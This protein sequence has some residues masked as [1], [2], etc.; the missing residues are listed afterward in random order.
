V[1]NELLITDGLR[2]NS[3]SGQVEERH[4]TY[5]WSMRS[6]PWTEDRMNLVTVTVTYEVQG[7]EYDVT[8]ATLYDSTQLSATQM[9]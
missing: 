4:R 7:K 3:A 9:Q 6:E 1:L 8:L 2:Q 5:Y